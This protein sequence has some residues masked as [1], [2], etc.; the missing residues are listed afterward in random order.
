MSNDLWRI[1]FP[2]DLVKTLLQVAFYDHHPLMVSVCGIQ[3]VVVD[4][5]FRFESKWQ[6]HDSFKMDLIR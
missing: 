3:G 2:N 4:R 6:T 1:D 5:P